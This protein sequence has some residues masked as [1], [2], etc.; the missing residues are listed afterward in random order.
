MLKWYIPYI[1]VRLSIYTHY[2]QREIL[3]QD[4]KRQQ[5]NT[6]ALVLFI[7]S[8]RSDTSI[9]PTESVFTLITLSLPRPSAE[10]AF[11]IE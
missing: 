6:S 2:H 5:F 10:A 8:S 3:K 1:K 4:N 7:C 9:L 11:C